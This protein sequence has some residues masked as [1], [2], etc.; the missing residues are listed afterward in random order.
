[1][2]RAKRGGGRSASRGTRSRRVSPFKF[3]AT[4]RY[5]AKGRGRKR[6]PRSAFLLPSKRKFPYRT[7]SGAVSCSMLSAAIKRAAQHGYPTVRAKAK[8]LYQRYCARKAA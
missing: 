6:L 4:E 8:R 2:A 7:G 3:T 5:Y 1:M